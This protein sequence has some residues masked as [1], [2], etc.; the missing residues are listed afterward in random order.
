M[1]RN[2]DLI[3]YEHC[4]LF[5]FSFTGYDSHL[6]LKQLMLGQDDTIK[7]MAYNTERMRNLEINRFKFTDSLSF[8]QGSLSELVDNLA[9]SGDT[10]DILTQKNIA[11]THHQKKLLLRKGVFP[12]DFATSLDKLEATKEIPPRES[13][14]NVLT[15]KHV[16]E[17]DYQHAV[18]VFKAFDC[19]NMLQYN[20][21]YMELDVCLLADVFSNFRKTMHSKF[22]LDA[23]HYISIP[24]F[25]YS[26]MLKVTE[27][28][29]D[30]I[31]DVD[32]YLFLTQNLKGGLS[33]IGNRSE[34]NTNK[35]TQEEDRSLLYYDANN[36]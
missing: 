32:I 19:E 13:F 14:F 4:G 20:N 34:S 30:Y 5:S 1:V 7:G 15:S 23:C 35:K 22:G 26:C 24:S 11:K 33:F 25:A 17:E 28:T 29:L 6:I 16:T 27:V 2:N 9:S 10:F 3:K 18:T 8:L 12:Y 36:L 21:L 31:R